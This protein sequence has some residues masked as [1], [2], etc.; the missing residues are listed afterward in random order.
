[1][2]KMGSL[3]DQF[4]NW[5]YVTLQSTAPVLK[6]AMVSNKLTPILMELG[7]ALFLENNTCLDSCGGLLCKYP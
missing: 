6:N 1:M 2:S 7:S 5:E 3:A 4:E